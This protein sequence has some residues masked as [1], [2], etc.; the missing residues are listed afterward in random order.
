MSGPARA[1]QLRLTEEVNQLR[2][3]VE[4][5]IERVEALE[6]D[7][8][9]IVTAP[10]SSAPA[11]SYPVASASEPASEPASVPYSV[12]PLT[13][14]RRSILVGIG[15]W[16]RT[17]LDGQRLGVSFRDALPESSQCY[18]VA[19]NIEG[20]VFDPVFVTRFYTELKA[21]IRRGNNS[22]PGDSVFI[23]LPCIR[24][25]QIVVNAARLGWPI[26]APQ[27]D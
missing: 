25:A 2:R 11:S 18:I 15:R 9:E 13:T 27:D 24:D 26:D 20:R 7:R 21:Q 14:E 4:R 8:F 6:A 16:L 22:N 23:G 1:A 5:L 12:P 10:A 17:S 19:R 3:E